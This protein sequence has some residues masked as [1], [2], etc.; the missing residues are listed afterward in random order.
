[1][2]YKSYNIYNIKKRQLYVLPSTW[3]IIRISAVCYYRHNMKV[4]GS[5]IS[6]KKQKEDY[7]VPRTS[8]LA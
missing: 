8:M 1:M 7:L 2:L 5:Y 3:Y 4:G 6:M